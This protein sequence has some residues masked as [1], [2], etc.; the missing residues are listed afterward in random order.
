M[1]RPTRPYIGTLH[2]LNISKLLLL[3]ILQPSLFSPRIPC[4]PWFTSGGVEPQR[5]GRVKIEKGKIINIRLSVR[6]QVRSGAH[7]F[8]LRTLILFLALANQDSSLTTRLTLVRPPLLFKLSSSS[9]RTVED[10][11]KSFTSIIIYIVTVQSLSIQYHALFTT[12]SAMQRYAVICHT[13][14][15]GSR[16]QVLHKRW[17]SILYKRSCLS[18]HRE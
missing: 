7:S 18:T 12:S 16:R 9:R 14:S 8:R 6:C 3:R 4:Y 2:Y 13:D 15:R 1:L 17:R 11:I 10:F 5:F